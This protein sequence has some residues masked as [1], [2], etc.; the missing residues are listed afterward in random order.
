MKSNRR[1]LILIVTLFVVIAT[2]ID[3]ASKNSLKSNTR[4]R[5]YLKKA[6]FLAL[7]N[8]ASVKKTEVATKAGTKSTLSNKLIN[9]LNNKINK[10]H[11]K[12]FVTK[13]QNTK[14]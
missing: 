11:Q 10:I 13:I 12:I 2:Y 6:A 9:L 5:S 1:I 4:S 7:K 8:E 3:C 14:P